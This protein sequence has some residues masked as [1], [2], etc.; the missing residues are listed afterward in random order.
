MLATVG[1]TEKKGLQSI[2]SIAMDGMRLH[3]IPGYSKPAMMKPEHMASSAHLSDY[4]YVL[5]DIAPAS[6]LFT[7]TATR[8]EMRIRAGS[9]YK[10]K[11]P[12]LD[13]VCAETGGTNPVTMCKF[14]DSIDTIEIAPEGGTV[15]V[16]TITGK[17]LLQN[18]QWMTQER[19]STIASLCGTTAAWGAPSAI[20]ANGVRRFTVPLIGTWFDQ[21]SPYM[22]SVKTDIVVR[23]NF[24]NAV[25]AGT[26]VLSAS[27]LQLIFTEDRGTA[28]DSKKIVDM[29]MKHVGYNFFF[30]TILVTSTATFSPN[31]TTN[32]SLRAIQGKAVFMTFSLR[33]A[34]VPA[35]EGYSTFTA[36]EPASGVGGTIAFVDAAQK[37]ILGGGVINATKLRYIDYVTHTN[38]QFSQ[39]NAVY[40]IPF[41]DNCRESFVKCT[42]MN[43]MYFFAGDECNLNITPHAA[44]S[45]GTYYYDILVYVVNFC[46]LSDGH[47][48]CEVV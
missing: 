18:T 30:N 41:A 47:F 38:S 9:A 29:Y 21:S 15:K 6:T 10:L 45:S 22:Q 44:F 17:E 8:V 42:L 36:I 32:I 48:K 12:V 40:L 20:L 7:A 31:T 13:V 23:I 4:F 19:W 11:Y 43:G 34:N 5:P 3:S 2:S 46:S 26:G 1:P 25:S 39:S 16:Q 33:A 14:Y 24:R 28:E 35:S 27:G 37:S